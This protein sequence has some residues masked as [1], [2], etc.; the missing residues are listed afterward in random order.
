MK[1]IM[2]L[3]M[4]TFALGS[5]AR[6]GGEG[7][8]P[9]PEVSL[10]QVVTKTYLTTQQM[11]SDIQLFDEQETLLLRGRNLSYERKRF[12]DSVISFLPEEYGIFLRPGEITRLESLE[13]KALPAWTDRI[14]RIERNVGA[15]AYKGWLRNRYDSVMIGPDG[16]IRRLCQTPAVRDLRLAEGGRHDRAY[17]YSWIGSGLRVFRQDLVT[18]DWQEEARYRRLPS[19]IAG[20]LVWF[21]AREEGFYLSARGL[22][23]INR[24]GTK[25]FN[26]RAKK[27][28][29]L[30][31]AA[32]ALLLLTNLDALSLFMTES[33]STATLLSRVRN[34]SDSAMAYSDSKRTLFLPLWLES[35]ST[36]LYEF[37]LH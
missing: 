4:I 2:T 24:E 5:F 13:T 20:R 12:G 18:C 7:P 22:V 34:F 31:A 32:P 33:E 30:S 14:E 29:F 36:G 21:G 27:L 8:C 19:P 10:P 6:G 17:F 11:V 1:R 15:I 23:R 16:S 9:V 28:Y 25:V 3:A 35:D 37:T 26:V